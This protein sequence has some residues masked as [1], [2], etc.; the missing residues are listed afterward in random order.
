MLTPMLTT[1]TPESLIAFERR[2]ADHFEAGRLPGLI[3]LSGGNEQQL[4]DLFSGFERCESMPSFGGKSIRPVAPGDWV[5][6]THRSHY[7]ALLSGIPEATLEQ[8]ILEGRSMFV[9]A[10]PSESLGVH[11]LTSS[12]LAGTCA[13]AAGV[14]WD[15]KQRGGSEHV[16]C[17]LGDGAEDEGHFYEA[18]M[19]VHGH[20][21]PC[22]F[23]VEDNG[24][25]V[26]TTTK[27]RRG[28]H[29]PLI[30]WPPCVR[31]LVY[32]RTWPHAGTGC[33]QR[34]EFQPEAIERMRGAWETR[35]V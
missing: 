19:M 25:S 18:V 27:E 20:S 23:V 1:H 6:S 8:M 28:W 11:F 5:F 15:I 22:T 17:F 14:A 30:F 2:I 10:K 13:I 12:V 7:H 9:F 33:A 35:M 31:R 34:V 21:L 16:W 4:I 3:H 24:V 29:Q 32:Q 26:D